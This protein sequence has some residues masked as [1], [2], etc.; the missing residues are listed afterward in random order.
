MIKFRTANLS[1]IENIMKLEEKC[2]NEH[3]QEK[4][5]V[6]LERIEVF[7]DGFIIMELDDR[8]IGAISS[9]IWQYVS[10]INRDTFMLG[11]SIKKQLKLNGNE[12][13]ISS[14]GILPEYRAQGFG[15]TLFNELIKNIKVKYPNVIQG[16]LLLSED[17][18][19]ARQIYLQN[20][21][22]DC[23]IFEGF[24]MNDDGIKK[25]GIVMRKEAL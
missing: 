1:D 20:N 10:T 25:N 23:K 19:D 11:H 15:V 5:E 8:F 18:K 4:M 21:F 14:I 24:F 16:I 9:E 12:L 13:Y 3:T 2:F 17:W 7:S 22:K 6:Y